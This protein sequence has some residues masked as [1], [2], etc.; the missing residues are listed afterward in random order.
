MLTTSDTLRTLKQNKATVR[1]STQLR[2]GALYLGSVLCVCVCVY[3]CAWLVN[4]MQIRELES[5]AETM[6]HQLLQVQ[7][8]SASMRDNLRNPSPLDP[9][10]EPT[11][12]PTSPSSHIQT[13]CFEAQAHW[14]HAL[15]AADDT[16]GAWRDATAALAARVAQL[17]AA[18]RTADCDIEYWY[19]NTT[20]LQDK[21]YNTTHTHTHIDTHMHM[22]AWVMLGYAS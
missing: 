1:R 22:H 16:A 20:Q 14:A 4:V 8:Q 12:M 2:I 6:R 13:A 11:D 10:E 9:V 3:V 17:E 21:V 19:Q 18:V 7:A 15:R 5:L